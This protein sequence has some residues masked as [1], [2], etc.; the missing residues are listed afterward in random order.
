MSFRPTPEQIVARARQ[1]LGHGTAYRLGAGGVYGASTADWRYKA[2]DC[3]GFVSWVLQVQRFATW[4]IGATWFETSRIWKDATGP[5]RWFERLDDPEV[6]C[7]VVYPDRGERQG[8]M[9]IVT[10]VGSA[11]D[12]D[13]VDCS[14]GSWRKYRDAVQERGGG[15]VFGPSTGRVFCRLKR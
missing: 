15:I 14:L 9:G 3:S 12:F 8:H 1:A 11:S 10:R 4:R 2:C 6:G 5:H 13:V 7:I